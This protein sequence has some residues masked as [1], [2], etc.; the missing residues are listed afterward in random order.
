MHRVWR[1]RSSA[2]LNKLRIGLGLG[3]CHLMWRNV[4]LC[5]SDVHAL[6]LNI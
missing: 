6:I 3:S 2:D 5:D 1:I 4:K